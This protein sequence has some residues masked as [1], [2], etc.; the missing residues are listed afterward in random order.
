VKQDAIPE[1]FAV[2]IGVPKVDNSLLK[3]KYNLPADSEFGSLP[4]ASNDAALMVQV[5]KA[6][7]F[8]DKNIIRLGLKPDDKVKAEDILLAINNAGE[9]IKANGN[10]N[11]LFVFYYSGHGHQLPDQPGGDEKK[12]HLDEV[13]VAN[14]DFIRDDAINK[15]FQ[16]YFHDTRNI[17]LVDAC[18]AGTLQQIFSLGPSSSNSL[19]VDNTGPKCNISA[20]TNVDE[21]V[22]MIY[23]GSSLD[24]NLSFDSN[25]GYFTRALVSLHNKAS[26]WRSLK[27]KD[28]ACR[29]SLQMQSLNDPSRGKIQYMELGS[30]PVDFKN[31]Y[32][33]K[34]K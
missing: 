23:Y 10:K 13:L 5:L 28:L 26:N 8:K 3:L 6:E 11:N 22:S 14:N 15:L 27:P 24:E 29:V 33:F 20:E 16:T 31:N 32:L 30:F 25:G 2:V 34:F 17:M 18:H 1:A 12:D 9:M 19:N 4:G 21:N 7:G